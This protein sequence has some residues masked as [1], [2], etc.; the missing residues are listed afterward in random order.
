MS[1]RRT[2]RR[3]LD[4]RS[5]SPKSLNPSK[6]SLH[7]LSR[8]SSQTNPNPNP[9]RSLNR[10]LNRSPNLSL[11]LSQTQPRLFKLSLIRRNLRREDH[12]GLDRSHTKGERVGR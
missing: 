4:R 12:K 5:Q 3:H 6:A 8:L 11:S 7:S 1:L 9:N 10:S 2:S